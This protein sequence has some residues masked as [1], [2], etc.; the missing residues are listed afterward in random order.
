MT[1]SFFIGVCILSLL[2]TGCASRL[3]MIDE[4]GKPVAKEEIEQRRS[5][6][7]F[8]L[9]AIGGGALSFGASFFVGSLVDRSSDSEN[10]AALWTITGTG[11]ILGT[12]LFAHN[13]RVRDF[14]V[15]VETV[16][17]SRKETA[18]QRISEEQKRQAQLAEEK[19]KLEGERQKQEAERE[20]LLQ[21]IRKKQQNEKN[22]P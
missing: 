5:N 10:H 7:N 9:F 19:K 22:K 21:E 18:S 6:K 1:K 17:D 20:K 12:A 8:V 2:T 14:N 15:A 4:M 3:S 13:G 11:T 16:K